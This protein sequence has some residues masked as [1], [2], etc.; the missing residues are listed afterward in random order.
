MTIYIYIYIYKI[1]RFLSF[2]INWI[3]VCVCACLFVYDHITLLFSLHHWDSRSSAIIRQME[4][5]KFYSLVTYIYIYIYIYIVA[6]VCVCV[7]VWQYT[8]L[9]QTLELFRFQSADCSASMVM[10]SDGTIDPLICPHD[11]FLFQ[12]ADQ[13]LIRVVS[14]WMDWWYCQQTENRT[15]LWYNNNIQFEKRSWK[16]VHIFSILGGCKL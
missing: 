16:M 1:C 2:E 11:V 10:L 8:R 15:R 12:T 3:N 9:S 4:V 5:D 14:W 7:C 13:L 6:C